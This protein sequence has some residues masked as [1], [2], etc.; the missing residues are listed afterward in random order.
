MGGPRDGPPGSSSEGG[1]APLGLPGQ[2]LGAPRRSRGTPRYSDRPLVVLVSRREGERAK[3][4]AGAAPDLER[5]H[6]EQELVDARLGQLFQEEVL[7]D[8]DPVVGD[9]QHVH[10]EHLERRRPRGSGDRG[11]LLEGER[12]VADDAGARIDQELRAFHARTGREVALVERWIRA[13]VLS[14]SRPDEDGVAA[15]QLDALGLGGASEM[16]GGDL[17][18]RRQPGQVAV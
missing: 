12:V 8:V 4:G 6:D 5:R 15:F 10:G 7:D 9:E 1:Y 3:S 13:E 18:L 14:P 17:E 16:A 11:T 2:T